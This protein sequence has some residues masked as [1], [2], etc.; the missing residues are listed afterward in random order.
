MA[1]APAGSAPALPQGG[2]GINTGSANLFGSGSSG[3]AG[4]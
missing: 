4:N 2:C 1:A 3:S